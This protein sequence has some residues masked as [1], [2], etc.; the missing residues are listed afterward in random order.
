MRC[1]VGQEPGQP[2]GG[3][4]QGGCPLCPGRRS[5]FSADGALCPLGA[6][7]LLVHEQEVEDDI[8]DED[9]VNSPAQGTGAGCA[10]FFAGRTDIYVVEST[11]C[12]SAPV[13]QC[14][15]AP[16]QQAEAARQGGMHLLTMNSGS[17]GDVA[18]SRK[19]TSN[20]VTSA[21]KMRAMP[22]TESHT[23]MNVDVRGSI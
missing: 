13:H 10:S 20:G 18:A 4:C 7:V 1:G 2:C 23:L 21:V 6:C 16:M 22:V 3:A 19:A 15:N 11:Q 5:L 14:T 8:K 17:S 12:T 9:E